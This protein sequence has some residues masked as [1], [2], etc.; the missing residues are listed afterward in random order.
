M[1]IVAWPGLGISSVGT[2]PVLPIMGTCRDIATQSGE[3]NHGALDARAT[4]ALG[5]EHCRVSRE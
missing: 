1:R 5:R 4:E 2:H 3:G